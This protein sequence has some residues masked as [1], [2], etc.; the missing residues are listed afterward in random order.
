MLSVTP[1]K[2]LAFDFGAESGRAVLGDVCSGVITMKEM[3]RFPNQP[4]ESAG[5]LRWDVR[6]LWCEVQS[7]LARVADIELDGIGVDA[8]GVDYALL[9][10]R[11]E[12]LENPYHY[13]DTRTQGMMERVF[14]QVSREEIY[15]TTGIQFMPINTLYQLFA[16]CHETPQLL[17][18][19]KTLVTIPDLF[20]FWLTGK[21]VCEFTNATTTQMVNAWTRTW[22]NELMDRLHLPSRLPAEIVEPGT[23]IGS[24]LECVAGRTRSETPV[25]APASHDTGS[26]VAAITA[27]NGTA[28]LSS[29]TWS[30]VGTEIDAPI[31]TADALG[32]NFTNE[33]GVCNT[34]RFLRNVMGL[35]MLQGCRNT[36]ASEGKPVAYDELMNLARDEDSFLH[37]VDPDDASFLNP[38]NMLTAID[39]YCTRTEQPLP[40]RPGAYVRTVLES[41]AFKYRSVIES[42][43]ELTGRRIEQIRVIGG[44]SKNRV[45]NQ[46][47]ADATGKVVVAGPA[48]ATSIGNIAVQ[49]L[50]TGGATSL[51]EVRSMVEHSFPVE[52][53]NPIES[54]RWN[55]NAKRFEHYTKAA[56]A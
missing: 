46:L 31:I 5:S 4:L 32:R 1:K 25:I 18:A 10:E 19:A 28:F 54:D 42:L 34:T 2:Y 13:R 8:W 45:L 39:R 6:R 53:F 15:I 11:G 27:G 17:Q 52:V 33:G 22:A 40:Q 56:N 37:L 47:T 50:A 24:L 41:L 7:A 51:A 26:A 12:L 35:W 30:L 23:V 20:H 3:H 21:A 43:E 36:W 14:Q 29:G 9:N 55:D 38:S 44:G 49:I 16:A 48:E